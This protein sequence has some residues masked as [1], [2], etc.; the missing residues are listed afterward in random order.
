M[1][2]PSKAL[3]P[4]KSKLV[5]YCT[6]SL[7]RDF[8]ILIRYYGKHKSTDMQCGNATVF[9]TRDRGRVKTRSKH[10]R[11]K[12]SSANGP[13]VKASAGGECH[14]HLQELADLFLVSLVV[15]T[16]LNATMK[17]RHRAFK[18]VVQTAKAGALNDSTDSDR[19][20]RA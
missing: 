12:P 8:L 6:I 19:C 3:I 17:L 7:L 4:C 20:G 9:Y 2:C 10:Q 16:L 13:R 11:A 18:T 1:I 14:F 15:I 5:Y